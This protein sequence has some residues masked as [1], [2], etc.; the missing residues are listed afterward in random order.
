MEIFIHPTL[1]HSP[2]DF[3]EKLDSVSL[4]RNI[5]QQVKQKLCKFFALKYWK[6]QTQLCNQE[7]IT[8]K[9]L[10]FKS[11]FDIVRAQ[12]RWKWGVGRCESRLGP[13]RMSKNKIISYFGVIILKLCK[14]EI[15]PQKCTLWTNYARIS[16]FSWHQNSIP[17]LIV[18]CCELVEVPSHVIV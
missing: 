17:F 12:R 13:S 11:K 8:T 2:G 14:W 6:F 10:K 16:K 15:F 1:R 9:Y 18:F 7:L 5:W 3:C 4:A